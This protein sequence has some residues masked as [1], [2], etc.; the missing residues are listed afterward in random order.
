MRS[1]VARVA[2]LVFASGLCALVYQIAWTRDFRLVFG[3][4]TGASAAVLAIF[5]G[6]LGVGGIVLGK[7]AER[8][9]RPLDLYARLEL[10]IALSTA[11]TPALLWLARRAY[12]ALGGTVT[13]GTIGGA[14]LRLALATLVLA[15]PTLLMGGT[16]PAAAR[17]VETDDDDAR[18]SVALLYG[19]N[20][21]GA[22]V[23]CVA[24]N[25]FLLEALG[26]HLT[27]WGAC[28]LNALV[29]V[30]A[31]SLARSL[32]AVAADA[33]P[34]STEIAPAAPRALVLAAASVVGF[35]F[36]LME[37]VWYRML[38]PLLG[39]TIFTFGLILAVALFG[40][41]IG[42]AAYGA[43]FA[44]R[45]ARLAAFAITCLIEALCVA[46]PYAIGDRIAL[47][48][49]LVRPV[50]S[51]GFGGYVLGWTA[52][53]SIVVLPAAVIAGLQFPMLIALLGKGKRSIGRDIG[54][55]YAF[56][57][58]GAIAGALAGGFG[59]LPLLSA[60]GCW[61]LVVMLLVATGVVAMV[62]AA[63]RERRVTTLGGAAALAT[64]VLTMLRA[65]G[66]T[67]AWRH[68]AIGAGRASPY[69]VASPNAATAFVRDAR[70]RIAWQVDGVESSV[71]ID[72]DSG[73]AFVINGK[74]DGHAR[75]DA[76]TQVM[77]GLLGAILHPNP[78]SAMVIGLGTGS[79]AGWLGRVPSIDRV[80]VVE[81]E[82]AILEVARWCAPANEDVLSNPKVHVA[83]GDGR[84]LLSVSRSRYDVIFSEPSNPYRAGIASL[85]TEEFYRAVAAHLES[86]G[87]FLQWVQAYE[88]DARTVRTIYATLAS[89]FPSLETWQAKDEDVILVA[90]AAPIAHDLAA[91]GARIERE[92][93]ARALRNAWRVSN[94]SGF[95]GHHLAR[96]SFARAIAE[97]HHGD[98]N[99]DD[100]PVVEFGFAKSL[101][102]DTA[103]GSG[104]I[105]DL[106]RAR[107]ESLPDL[108]G[109]SAEHVGF[110]QAAVWIESGLPAHANLS[111]SH[112]LQE[113]LRMMGLWA[114][115][116][117]RG[118]YA[119]WTAPLPQ[120]APPR[121]PLMPLEEE[122]VAEIVAQH[123]ERE[124]ARR[125]IESLRAWNPTLADGLTG[126]ALA[127]DRR[128]EEAL[129]AFVSS[130]TRYRSDP[131]PLLLSMVRILGAAQEL[132]R[133][134]V[135]A[136]VPL[137]RALEAPFALDLLH[138]E[139]L[140]AR[141]ALARRLPLQKGC[142]DVLRPLE[143]STPWAMD[144]LEWRRDCY[145][146]S[147]G[148][149]ATRA[150]DELQEFVDHHPFP[151]GLGVSTSGMP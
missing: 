151:F 108:A 115:G 99:T 143:P 90:S 54:A 57:T 80:D 19:V 13:L 56:N 113:R 139:R 64:A 45:P 33:A 61:R 83:R 79:T 136:V 119:I 65:D 127:R 24:A 40:I 102:R 78:K 93:Y 109:V 86:G 135:R 16:L 130:F 9:A 110:A 71:A 137:L 48:A 81:L 123:G 42:G 25:F 131:W 8:R 12:F 36:F 4:S 120:D 46:V 147:G 129:A 85:Y 140:A 15:I 114:R 58:L 97:A 98:L 145:A 66:P 14:A 67:A 75:Q 43:F 55:A 69:A 142:A 133:T 73:Y 134:D 17:A 105:L 141:V 149:D 132:A 52:V 7:R 21:L 27:L 122:I 150:E 31:R 3:A 47:L 68:S 95:L 116:D 111:L 34:S 125:A 92:P 77:G 32:P 29:G 117:T 74:L 2:P 118:A 60:T 72:S 10:M 144:L 6:G 106:S 53:A 49:L 39:G 11:A 100:E 35:A 146:L 101:G 104:A 91:L 28:L 96:P 94:A 63:T 62:K 89:V 30:V 126:V 37:I 103:F 76:G 128:S 22:V 59:L 18:R 1:R 112:E 87:I 84:E 41:G 82:P 26:T 88:V 124:E 23:G 148:A 38:G 138:G 50:G 107:H 44:N 121:T 5:M 51:L 70:R 20:T